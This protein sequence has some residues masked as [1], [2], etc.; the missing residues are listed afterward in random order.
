MLFR[1]YISLLLCLA[2]VGCG[3]AR[4]KRVVVYCAHD[5]EFAEP[6]L[7]DFASQTGLEIIPRWD[8]EANKSVGLYE[9]LVR[10]QQQPRCD[11]HWNNEVLATIR[12]QRQGLLAA[13]K[14]PAAQAFPAAFKARDDA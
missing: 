3:S 14:S 2:T 5:R 6:I 8:T 9:D 12:L 7:K 11:V 10:E 1:R 4:E 13:Y